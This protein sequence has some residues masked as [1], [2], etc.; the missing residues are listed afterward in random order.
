MCLNERYHNQ[1]NIID[2][3]RCL[4]VVCTFSSV[5]N[6]FN[7]VYFCLQLR[8]YIVS[9]HAHMQTRSDRALPK[10]YPANHC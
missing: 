10:L 6:T 3:D 9:V 7:C 4:N 2:I 8:T 5:S 1:V